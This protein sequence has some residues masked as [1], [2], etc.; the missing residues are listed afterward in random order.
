M[1][2][3]VYQKS[4]PRLGLGNR[5]QTATSSMIWTLDFRVGEWTVPE[6]LM[7]QIYLV[8]LLV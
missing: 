3:Q 1:A 5:L 8:F 7:L 4:V 6:D 2:W